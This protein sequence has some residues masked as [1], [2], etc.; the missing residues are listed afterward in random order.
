[1]N[2]ECSLKL[3]GAG[4]SSLAADGSHNL[5]PTPF[6]FLLPCQKMAE[7]YIGYWGQD[8]KTG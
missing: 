3:S 2:T 1:M 4:V 8:T 6:L 7:K 5:F